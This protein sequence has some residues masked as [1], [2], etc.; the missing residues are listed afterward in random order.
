ME[1]R[2]VDLR[3]LKDETGELRR[4]ETVEKERKLAEV[5]EKLASL[6]DLCAQLE[7]AKYVEVVKNPSQTEPI[8]HV[9]NK[10]RSENLKCGTINLSI[11]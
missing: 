5:E 4:Q 3:I 1:K 6:T 11:K 7:K 10:K 9:Y 2:L 8:K